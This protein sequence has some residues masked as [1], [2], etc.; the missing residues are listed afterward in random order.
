M[1]ETRSESPGKQQDWP[2]EI[3]P[4][5]SLHLP[6]GIS[7]SRLASN[8]CEWRM[9]SRLSQVRIWSIHKK[10]KELSRFMLCCCISLP[11]LAHKPKIKMALFLG[12]RPYNMIVWY[13]QQKHTTVPKSCACGVCV[14]G[15]GVFR[16]IPPMRSAS[17]E[18]WYYYANTACLFRRPLI[19][20]V[21]VWHF[22]Y[23]KERVTLIL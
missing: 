1:S 7:A 20:F 14:C 6:G 19:A 11:I 18:S 17:E 13:P 21:H 12:I 8:A 16:P 10:T 5:E 4:N 2:F 22:L 9:T 3:W 15:G 23:C